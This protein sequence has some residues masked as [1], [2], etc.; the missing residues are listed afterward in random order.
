MIDYARFLAAIAL[1]EGA[2]PGQNLYQI[3]ERFLVQVNKIVERNTGI[4]DV[5]TLADRNDDVMAERIV[6]HWFVD[7]TA[8]HPG[9]TVY[10]AALE[11]NAG[12][13]G[14]KHPKQRHIIYAHMCQR[15][16]ETEDAR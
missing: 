16:Y 4:S 3:T 8:R 10:D 5:F 7:W 15:A 2:D 1:I 6:H 14:A 12:R 11:Y 9:G 13:E